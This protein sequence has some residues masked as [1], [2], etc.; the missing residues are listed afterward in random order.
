MGWISGID[1]SYN[2][3]ILFGEKFLVSFGIC[4][5]GLVTVSRDTWRVACGI[6]LLKVRLLV[7]GAVAIDIRMVCTALNREKYTGLQQPSGEHF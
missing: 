7:E 1:D 6:I 3:G 4:A 5:H 2:Q